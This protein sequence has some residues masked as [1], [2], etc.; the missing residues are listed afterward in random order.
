MRF[1]KRLSCAVALTALLAPGAHAD[2]RNQLTYL[3]FN[4]PVSLPGIS[5]G[6]GTYAFEIA[7][8]STGHV[9]RV[10]NKAHTKTYT[11]LFT[12]PMERAD[13]RDRTIVLFNERPLGQPQAIKAWFYPG[14]KTGEEFV[15][16]KD[17]AMAIA[18]AN[19]GSVLSNDEHGSFTHIDASGQAVDH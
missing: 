3:T 16:P 8:A 10:L 18:K 9:V 5:L 1:I 14:R 17:Q 19:D 2:D 7:N 15:Y 4:G 12:V 6:P 13:A 11:T